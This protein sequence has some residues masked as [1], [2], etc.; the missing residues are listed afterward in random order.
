MESLKLN[1]CKHNGYKKT[2]TSIIPLFHSH[3]NELYKTSAVLKLLY[4]L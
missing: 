2:L 3:N 4:P 1:A